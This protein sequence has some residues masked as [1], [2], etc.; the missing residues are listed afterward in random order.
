MM[1]A[2]GVMDLVVT[3]AEAI[4]MDIEDKKLNTLKQ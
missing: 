2:E 4:T 3:E 1:T